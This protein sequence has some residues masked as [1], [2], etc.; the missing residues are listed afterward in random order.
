MGKDSKFWGQ[1]YQAGK[2][3][4]Q[5]M[6]LLITVGPHLSS[7]HSCKLQLYAKQPIMK[8]VCF[9]FFLIK[10]IRKRHYSKTCCASQACLRS[11]P[12]PTNLY[13]SQE[14]GSSCCGLPANHN[15]PTLSDAILCPPCSWLLA[16][17][18]SPGVLDMEV[19]TGGQIQE[20]THPPTHPR[21]VW[22]EGQ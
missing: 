11:T 7:I 19:Q 5:C 22:P 15:Y 6:T 21:L 2:T 13:I 20:L 16:A 17:P 10:V 4:V 14:A 12:E 3:G 18:G 8:P 1:S 9:F